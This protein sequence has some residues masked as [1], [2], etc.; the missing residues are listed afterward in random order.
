[1]TKRRTLK[2]QATQTLAVALLITATL[3]A[4]V[5]AQFT[6]PAPDTT[7]KPPE[8]HFTIR[9]LKVSATTLPDDNSG[10]DMAKQFKGAQELPASLTIPQEKHLK[11]IRQL[12]FDGENAEAYLSPDGKHLSFQ[13]RSM[14]PSSCDQIFTMTLD[15][16]NVRRI[17]GG[18]GRTTCSYYLPGN[19]RV[20][21]AS[22]ESGYG[23]ACPPPPDMS[24]GYV[25]SLDP[26]FDIYVAD[27][28]G[29]MLGKLTENT[30][31]DAEAMISPKGDRIV[32][33]S[34]RSG[35]V[36]LYSMNIDG[37]DVKQL[38]TEEGYDGGAFYSQDGSQI[39]YRA[40][41]P[42]G[43]DLKEYRDLLKKNLIKPHVLEIFVMDADGGH[44][45]QLTHSG[46]AS[47]AP[48]FF[49]D[50]KRV[51]FSS[52]MN[53]PKGR[54]FELYTV[55][56]DGSGLEQITFDKTFNSFPIFTPDGKH[57][58]FSSNRNAAAPHS[59]NI[60]IADWVE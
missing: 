15:G 27:T 23:G 26:A 31:Y 24:Q 1:M 59:T 60:F 53:D 33:T 30:A 5:F 38:T 55:K 36:D 28:A 37:S 54:N 19:D 4:K 47:F 58:I 9:T 18:H 6:A 50:G 43:D 34:T 11:N 14:D 35:D 25:W 49:P 8:H 29:Q 3:T 13:A 39:V 21:F 17:S 57:L 46:A 32:F 2:R 10:I 12:T 41:R 44:K 20:L 48:Y 52:N 56:T 51:I 16:K 42:A 7:K 22:T 40:S 45:R